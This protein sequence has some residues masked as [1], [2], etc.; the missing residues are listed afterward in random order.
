MPATHSRL[1]LE[2]CST[3]V[4]AALLHHQI[5][6]QTMF[7]GYTNSSLYT[8]SIEYIDIP[9]TPSY[10]YLPLDCMSLT[11]THKN[12]LIHFCLALSVQGNSIT[13]SSGTTAVID[14]GTTNI[15]GP[16]S[17]I[18]A[19]YAQIPNSQPATGEWAG[20]YSYREHIS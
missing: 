3:W 2:E 10:W 15:A 16:S 7:S 12:S 19:I 17:A 6:T 20:Y 5:P 4:R 14:T 11:V 18:Q 13:I 9:G 8:G 1:S